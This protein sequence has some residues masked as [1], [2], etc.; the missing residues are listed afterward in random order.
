M[1]P[2]VAMIKENLEKNGARVLDLEL[3]FD[4]RAVLLEN[5]VYL[6][7]SL[8]LDQIDVVFA[9]E[10]E[11]KIKEDCCPGKPFSV[12]RSEPGVA[13][14]LLN[15]QPS[16]GL[17]TTTIDIRQGDSRDSII[18]R[19]SKVNRFIK[20]IIHCSF[21]YLSKVKLMRFEDPVLGPRRVPILGREEQGKLP[22]S[23]KSSFSISLADRKVLMTDNGLSVDIG[24]TLVYLVQ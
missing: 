4:E 16:N 13:V 7:N 9:S 22:I 1:M 17:F 24:D 12:F 20:G 18:R 8:E 2:F 15:P 3:E 10:A 19:L 5:L 6:T 23:D 14:S 11:D 21:R